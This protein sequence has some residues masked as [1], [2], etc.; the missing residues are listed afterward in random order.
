[1]APQLPKDFVKRCS[2]DHGGQYAIDVYYVTN[3]ADDDIR[4]ISDGYLN[5]ALG[6]T[7]LL[8]LVAQKSAEANQQLIPTLFFD[9][10]F[11]LQADARVRTMRGRY[12]RIISFFEHEEHE[13]FFLNNI[14][15]AANLLRLRFGLGAA[16]ER[17][18]INAP[19]QGTAADIIKRAMIAVDAWLQA[20]QPRVRMI[21]QV[22]DELVFEVHRDDVDAVAKQIHQLMENCTRLDVPLLVEVGSGENWDQAH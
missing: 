12:L 5:S 1:M 8:Q 3:L 18:A 20:E 21:M 10:S 16:A 4:T 9:G 22:H 15:K 7:S 11:S 19:M 17:A 13:S 2:T 14:E 6:E